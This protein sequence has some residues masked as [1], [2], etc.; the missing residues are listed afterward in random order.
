[1]M[2]D[3]GFRYRLQPLLDLREKVVREAERVMWARRQELAQAEVVRRE[4]MA[5][6]DILREYV[7]GRRQDIQSRHRSPYR[8]EAAARGQYLH[9]LAAQEQ[10]L[11]NRIAA[12]EYVIR[13]Q[14]QRMEA[15]RQDLIEKDRKLRVLRKHREH[16]YGR[17]ERQEE[18]E[19]EE[20]GLRVLAGKGWK[21]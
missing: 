5:E 15:A 17:F 2:T 13:E 20:M 6:L 21:W 19:P 11:R 7:E 18:A 14:I 8:R 4:L 10:E 9:G 12:Q 16:E 1:M 3:T